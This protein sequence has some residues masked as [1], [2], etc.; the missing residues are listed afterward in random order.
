MPIKKPAKLSDS[1][2][3]MESFIKT[4]K[5]KKAK[6]SNKKIVDFKKIIDFINEYEDD[7]KIK[8]NPYT[9]IVANTDYEKFLKKELVDL[10]D[11]V[12]D[13]TKTIKK[14]D[15]LKEK[16]KILSDAIKN[17][18][19]NKEQYK[20]ISALLEKSPERID[21]V[22][23]IQ[24]YN[25]NYNKN[26]IHLK[27]INI[28]EIDALLDEVNILINNGK[29]YI[30]KYKQN[31]NKHVLKEH[32]DTK[33]KEN[34]Y[35]SLKART[36]FEKFQKKELMENWELLHRERDES[37]S[38]SL[39]TDKAKILR[40]AFDSKLI[41]KEEFKLIGDKLIKNEKIDIIKEIQKYNKSYTKKE[42]SE[43]EG[44]EPPKP[45]KKTKSKRVQGE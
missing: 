12:H 36:P 25:K 32:K 18:N 24:K 37:V 20:K 23:E 41:S 1:S 45:V 13:Q 31:I 7:T 29:K 6:E 10:H 30:D 21:I 3:G 43:S 5:T 15:H 44:E 38:T 19:I 27:H 26:Y 9:S 2:E 11:R 40:D 34:P 33:I 39:L 42:E 8:E 4:T 28:K 35:K 17:K 14:I 16:R 22:K